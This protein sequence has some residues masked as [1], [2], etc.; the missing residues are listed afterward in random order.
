MRKQFVMAIAALTLSTV[1]VGCSSKAPT[2]S[3]MN[4]EASSTPEEKQPT[5]EESTSE[6]ESS[7]V[8]KKVLFQK[9]L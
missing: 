7:I 4:T 2:S 1:V 5:T 8:Q 3:E 6:P 9:K